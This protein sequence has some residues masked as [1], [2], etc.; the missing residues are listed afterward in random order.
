MHSAERPLFLAISRMVWGFSFEKPLDANRVPITP[1]VDD[2]VGGLTV[3]PAEF[4]CVIKPRTKEKEDIIR[5]GWQHCED[6]VLDPVTKQWIKVADGM[7]FSTY[8]PDKKEST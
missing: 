1:D 5:K 3:L 7:K 8:I 2:L 4:K 6:V